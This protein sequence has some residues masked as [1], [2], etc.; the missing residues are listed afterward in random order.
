[1]AK[2][3]PVSVRDHRDRRRPASRCGPNDRGQPCP[4]RPGA[5]A[6][7]L[8]QDHRRVNGQALDR[9]RH[10]PQA[11][12]CGPNDRGQPCP[13]RPGGLVAGSARGRRPDRSRHRRLGGG[14]VLA[15][16]RPLPQAR[17]DRPL[18]R[19]LATLG[20]LAVREHRAGLAWCA[21]PSRRGNGVRADPLP[22]A[23][24]EP[25]GRPADRAGERTPLSRA[26]AQ[27]RPAPARAPAGAGAGAAQPAALQEARLAAD[28]AGRSTAA[29]RS[30][31]PAWPERPDQEDQAPDRAGLGPADSPSHEKARPSG[32]TNRERRRSRSARSACPLRSRR[33]APTSASTGC[34]LGPGAACPSAGTER[35]RRTTRRHR[36]PVRRPGRRRGT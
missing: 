15:G 6:A 17:I 36:H 31:R 34:H 13:A 25:A 3:S 11:S 9:T 35:R 14:A 12:R 1:M 23:R 29:G 18:A 19:S 5:P 26:T 30:R 33:Q 4:A 32:P 10:R 28:S 20:A 7:Q 16:C 21:D 27:P 22:R 2:R 24:A 8:A